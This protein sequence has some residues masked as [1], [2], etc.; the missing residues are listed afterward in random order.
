VPPGPDAADI[1][2]A[3]CTGLVELCRL[4]RA[5]SVHVTFAPEDEWRFLGERGFLQRTDQQFHWQNAGYATFEDFLDALA[6]RKRKAIRRERRDA[7]SPGIEVEWLTR[8][9]LTETVWDHFFAFYME[10]GSRKW[11]RPYLTRAFYSLVGEQMGD[12]VLVVMLHPGRHQL[13]RF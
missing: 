7:L 10:T 6:S 1:R 5:S 9:E 4:R 8:T 11:G 2:A 13:H 12:R 3:V